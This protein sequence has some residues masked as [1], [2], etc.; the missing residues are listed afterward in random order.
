MVSAVNL[1]I[2]LLSGTPQLTHAIRRDRME[3]SEIG[4]F[5]GWR[6][7]RHFHLT[8]LAII[9]KP[10]T[11]TTGTAQVIL[12]YH[13][14]NHGNQPWRRLSSNQNYFMSEWKLQCVSY[15]PNRS[16]TVVYVCIPSCCDLSF[17]R[18]ACVCVYAAI[19]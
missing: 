6:I 4:T 16:M 7:S 19:K 5:D 3:K 18:H 17:V 8:S 9:H 12:P 2:S 14:S 11:L 1:F 13:H 15:W 10:A